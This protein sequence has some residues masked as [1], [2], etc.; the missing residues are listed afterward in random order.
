VALLLS[1]LLIWPLAAAAEDTGAPKY[2]AGSI[3][4]SASNTAAQYAPNTFLSIYGEN[5]AYGTR[6]ITPDDVRGG[7]LPTALGGAGVRVLI[8]L[9]P[10]NLYYV[11]PKQINILVPA[12][13]DSGRV[14]LQVVREGLAGPP[15]SLTL[16]PSA[17]AFFTSDGRNIIAT[18]AG[19]SLITETSPARRGEIVVMYATG[20]GRTA[21]PAPP[22]RLPQ[23][24]SPLVGAKDFRVI[25][26]GSLVDPRRVLYAGLTP[27]FAGLFQINLQIPDEAP[28]DPE[29]R[30]STADQIS[31]GGR[32]LWV[33]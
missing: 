13:F 24:V 30:V 8:N 17:P 19:G 16:D 18:H 33:R 12:S 15:V 32:F 29:I 3:A 27:G 31:L 1:V 7:E 22:N 20:L 4:N 10:A 6:A 26:N 9:V 23:G 21:P 25:L 11:S 14:T 2:T 5:L 28:A